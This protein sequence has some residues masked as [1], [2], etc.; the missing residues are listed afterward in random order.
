MTSAEAKKLRTGGS[1]VG[2]GTSRTDSIMLLH[3]PDS[4]KPTLISMQRDSW[5]Q[6]P[7]HGRN[8][9]N[10][11]FS[12]GGPKLLVQTVEQATGLR[13]DNYMEIG[14]GGFAGVVD[15]VGGVRMCLP[16]AVNDPYAHINLP[17]GCQN[18]QGADALGYVR[19]RHAF[20]TGDLARAQ[21]QREFLG[22]LMK[23]VASP[24]NL[25][26]PWRLKSVGE[27]GAQGIAVD[28]GMS[29]LRALK[30]MWTLKGITSGGQSVQVP[31][32]DA[33]YYVGGESGVLWDSSRAK[34]LFDDLNNDRSISVSQ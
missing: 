34:K 22:A 30:I 8:K 32:A 24:A 33:N 29:P 20:A 1:N 26:V 2:G 19:S 28:Q 3:V 5:V 16:E 14:F 7:G 9:I 21:H 11:A 10:S 15:A 4:G 6:I 17:K 27:S 12:I 18:L 13:V 25:L 31:V 23:K